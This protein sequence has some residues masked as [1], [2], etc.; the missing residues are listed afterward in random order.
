[1]KTKH[2]T[3]FIILFFQLSFAAYSLTGLT[4]GADCGCEELA[5]IRK[6]DRAQLVGKNNNLGKLHDLKFIPEHKL[7]YTLSEFMA[8]QNT[9]YA[10]SECI[11]GNYAKYMIG[12]KKRIF[13]SDKVIILISAPYSGH[14]L[15]ATFELKKDKYFKELLQAMCYEPVDSGWVSNAEWSKLTGSPGTPSLRFTNRNFSNLGRITEGGEYLEQNSET[16]KYITATGLNVM[17]SIYKSRANGNFNYGNNFPMPGYL[18]FASRPF[19]AQNSQLQPQVPQMWPEDVIENP[20]E[21][22]KYKWNVRLPLKAI[23]N[24]GKLESLSNQN[25]TY[26]GNYVMDCMGNMYLIGDAIHATGLGGAAVVSAGIISIFNGEVV[27]IDNSSGHYRPSCDQL[28]NAI[29]YLKTNHAIPFED[30]IPNPYIPR[31]CFWLKC[32][33][34]EVSTIFQYNTGENTLYHVDF[35]IDD[36]F[37]IPN[38]VVADKSSVPSSITS[39]VLLIGD[40]ANQISIIYERENANSNRFVAN[41]QPPS[42]LFQAS[43]FADAK[44]TVIKPSNYIGLPSSESAVFKAILTNCATPSPAI[45]KGVENDHST[46]SYK[47]SPN[48]AQ[49]TLSLSFNTSKA[50]SAFI[51]S[52]QNMLGEVVMVKEILE[53]EKLDNYSIDIR[54]LPNGVYII[55]MSD[56]YVG[57]TKF[58]IVK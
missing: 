38:V 34:Y 43:A 25:L 45:R 47:V 4:T 24:N 28:K 18:N 15:Q 32:R 33:V 37:Y 40:I 16:H 12:K 49:N 9:N 19:L 27:F 10:N 29:N 42:T 54:H 31:V 36:T 11:G 3:F 5:A 48:P 21:I 57:S 35:N 53:G 46:M 23:Y 30:P 13:R 17:N 51:I 56:L 6:L 14:E 2:Y 55:K 58:V 20:E 26:G 52:I 7:A 1:M 22:Y 39:C 50:T 8:L 44:L 41:P